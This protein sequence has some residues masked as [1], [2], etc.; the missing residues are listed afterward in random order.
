MVT[1][2]FCSAVMRS[3]IPSVIDSASA[4]TTGIAAC[5][6]MDFPLAKP[7]IVRTEYYLI[8]EGSIPSFHRRFSKAEIFCNNSMLLELTLEA[9]LMPSN[10]EA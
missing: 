4:I 3:R 6:S 9:S 5:A 7:A 2:R 1:F 8:V 10:L